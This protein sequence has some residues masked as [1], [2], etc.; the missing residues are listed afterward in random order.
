MIRASPGLNLALDYLPSS[1][2]FDPVVEKTAPDLASRIVWFDAYVTNVDRTVR[3]TNMLMWHRRLWLIDHGAALYFHHAWT[4]HDAHATSPFSLIKDHV[5]LRLAGLLPAIDEQMRT[6]LSADGLANIVQLIPDEWLPDDPGFD[7]KTAQREAYL[8]F[9]Q[10][11]L[12]SSEI[13][14]GEALRARTAHL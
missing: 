3:N 5:L 7:G 6:V 8:N 10:V 14:V 13:F 1:V 12:R 9:F 4:R 11:R 2:M